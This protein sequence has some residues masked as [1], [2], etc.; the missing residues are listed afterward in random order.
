MC[1]SK[2]R[3]NYCHSNLNL[4]R[5]DLNINTLLKQVCQ[6]FKYVLICVLCVTLMQ[7]FNISIQNNG[8]TSRWFCIAQLPMK[9]Y[10]SSLSAIFRGNGHFHAK[11]GE[12][13]I[14]WRVVVTSYKISKRSICCTGENVWFVELC[15]RVYMFYVHLDKHRMLRFYIC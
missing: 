3:N 15:D 14:A 1:I 4:T 12:H 2:L 6:I 5:K 11:N 8:T 7:Q 10:L 9:L 13:V